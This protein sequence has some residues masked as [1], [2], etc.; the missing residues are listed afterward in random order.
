[1]SNINWN[2]EVNGTLYALDAGNT[3]DGQFLPLH[4][5]INQHSVLSTLIDASYG[6]VGLS[7]VNK[8]LDNLRVRLIPSR[9]TTQQINVSGNPTYMVDEA[10][11]I[12][13]CLA[14]AAT[15]AFPNDPLMFH[16]SSLDESSGWFQVEFWDVPIGSKLMIDWGDGSPIE[17]IISDSN[18]DGYLTPYHYYTSVDH[19]AKFAIDQPIGG[20]LT[21][22]GN[23]D[24][25]VSFGSAVQA[26]YIEIYKA[27]KLISVPAMLPEYINGIEI[28]ACK[29]LNDSNISLWDTSHITTMISMF[30]GC[31]SFNQPLNTWDVSKVTNMGGMLL[32]ATAFNQDLSMWCVPLITSKP[33]NFASLSALTPEHMPVW[34]TC[35]VIEEVPDYIPDALNMSFASNS[36]DDRVLHLYIRHDGT[37]SWYVQDVVNDKLIADS[38]GFKADGVQLEFPVNHV[39]KGIVR[40]SHTDKTE[41]HYSVVGN[42]DKIFAEHYS[43][44]G[45]DSVGSGLPSEA[46]LT[47]HGYSPNIAAYGF[48]T[49]YADLI[50]PNELASHITDLSYMFYHCWLFDQDISSW[51]VSNI[52]NMNSMFYYATLFNQDI[53]SWDVSSVTNMQFM[54]DGAALFNQNLS[55]WCVGLIPA[56]PSD[57]DTNTPSWT[58]P[59]PVWGTCPSG[60]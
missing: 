55:Q 50:L 16:I 10:G 46:S 14:P 26:G 7:L 11:V 32:E 18:N 9:T 23:I 12:S 2:I 19:V 45:R 48:S 41:R 57:F 31:T 51:D 37:E 54:F 25:V 21:Q 60:A 34:G 56:L 38:N 49:G 17:E 13:F 4:L 36:D 58:L 15:E 3:P 28:E 35:P 27:H 39:N 30:R 22:S 47:I 42:M 20:W 43:V 44:K 59:K 40:I 33:T 29:L 6:G 1:M 8:T 52:T 53:S 24:S 5:L